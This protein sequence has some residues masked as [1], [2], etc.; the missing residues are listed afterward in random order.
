MRKSIY[1][2]K[3]PVNT[4]FRKKYKREKSELKMIR[5]NGIFKRQI[6]LLEAMVLI[7][8]GTIGAGI[9]AIPYAVAQV[10]ILIGMIYLLA[11]GLLMIGLNL[12]IGEISVRTK[13]QYQIPGLANKYIG[14]SAA[15][16]MTVILYAMA[17]GVQVVYIIGIGESFNSLFGGGAFKWGIIFFLVASVFVSFGL[18]LIKKIGLFLVAF[19]LIIV[20]AMAYFA[21]PEINLIH[22]KHIGI[23]S[24]LFP[25]G[26]ILFGY[27]GIAAIPEAHSLLA[28]RPIV[29]KKAIIYSGIVIMF[30]YMLF[31]FISVGVTGLNTSE[32]ATIGLGNVLGPRIM[33]LGNMFAIL[34]MGTSFL[35][36]GVALRDS[37]IWDFKIRKWIVN[38]FVNG[39]PIFLFILGLRQF[40]IVLDLVGGVFVSTEMLMLILIYWK[41]KQLGDLS[42]GKYKLHHVALLAVILIIALTIGGIYSIVKLL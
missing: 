23:T 37:L 26:V 9:L 35:M 34:A 7:L 39:I 22:L 8:S 25:Y 19:I 33:W 5:L 1:K 27:S 6:S 12:M 31:S 40:I 28:D 42:V 36:N 38:I 20:F 21:V 10:G 2:I 15:Y 30:I 17:F 14:K 29:F 18:R 32:I 24:L 4:M 11:I 3:I 16:F 13:I 41:A